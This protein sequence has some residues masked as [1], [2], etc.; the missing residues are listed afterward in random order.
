[1]MYL[2]DAANIGP[3][4][5]PRAGTKKTGY[6]SGK[7]TLRLRANAPATVQEA[8]SIPPCYLYIAKLSIHFFVLS[9]A[10]S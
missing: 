10:M 9:A 6:G 5:D 4:T 1:M 3:R 8:V 2:F 7:E